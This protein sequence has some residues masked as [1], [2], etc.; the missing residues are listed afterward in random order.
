MKKIVFLL[1]VTSVS[2]HNARKVADSNIN[3][4]APGIVINGKLFTAVFQQR[5]AEYRALCFQ[6]FNIARLR[7][8][9]AL[10]RTV[11]RPAVITDIDETVLDNSP[12]AVHQALLG[13]DYDQTEWY[14]WTDKAMADTLPGVTTFL[15]YASLKGVEIFY[16]TN[17]A[18]REKNITLTNL[19]KFGLPDADTNHIFL[20]QTTSGKESRRQLVMKDHDILLL[21]GDNL[22][23]F[24][25]LFDKKTE[26][27][28]AKNADLLFNEFGNRFIVLPNPGYGDWESSLFNYNNNLTGHQKDSVIK[29]VLKTY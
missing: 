21:M 15:K 14:N 28:R 22:G 29:S 12:Y 19:Q 2:C 24:S 16:I 5:A 25:S 23:D 7:L 20:K 26:G 1:L 18:D 27:E 10:Q 11:K 8:D 6:A 13:K 4:A 3:T 9:Q 17:R